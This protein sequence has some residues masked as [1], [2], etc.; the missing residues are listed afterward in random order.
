MAE[1]ILLNKDK[2]LHAA[3]FLSLQLVACYIA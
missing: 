3:F 2:N 1:S